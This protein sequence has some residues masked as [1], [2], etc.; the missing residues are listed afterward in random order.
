M[1]TIKGL[2]PLSLV[3]AM[4]STV[5]V[6]AQGYRAVNKLQVV[7]L[8]G[9]AFEVIEARGEGARGIW[10]AAADYVLARSGGGNGKRLYVKDPRGP[11]VTAPGRK[12]V[13]FTTNPAAL[14]SAPTQSLSITVN[15]PG[16]GLPVN[17]A[18][19]FCRDYQIELDDILFRRLGK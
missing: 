4:L 16:V 9:G 12:G 17:H 14:G 6:A 3:L 1:L 5:P 2:G 10:C 13:T 7:P 19:Q 18:V 8:N 11:A 15:T